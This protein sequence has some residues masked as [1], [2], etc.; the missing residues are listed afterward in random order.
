MV[1]VPEA[2]KQQWAELRQNPVIY[3]EIFWDLWEQDWL[4][5]FDESMLLVKKNIGKDM[6]LSD[7]SIFYNL[8]KKLVFFIDF[9]RAKKEEIVLNRTVRDLY[10]H[11]VGNGLLKIFCF[12]DFS[13]NDKRPILSENVDKILTELTDLR[14]FWNDLKALEK[15]YP[16]I[17]FY[18]FFHRYLKKGIV[19][20]RKYLLVSLFLVFGLFLG[21]KCQ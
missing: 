9:L 21:I 5:Y 19:F 7:S 2:V 20:M 3:G 4:P 13:D 15:F 11:H 18:Y 10:A 14:I 6:S 12:A 16:F 17:R 1:M 8:I